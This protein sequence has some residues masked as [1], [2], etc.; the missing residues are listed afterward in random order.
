[1]QKYMLT[2][3]IILNVA[4][5]YG[6]HQKAACPPEP[7]RPPPPFDAPLPFSTA[8]HSG[9]E[10]Q[11]KMLLDA[12][13]NSFNFVLARNA[14]YAAQCKEQEGGGK[15]EKWHGKSKRNVCVRVCSVA[16]DG[17]AMTGGK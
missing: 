3:T 13:Q 7:R 14:H 11:I 10:I 5:N 1:M 8:D 4:S 15:W 12:M 6:C 17:T 9:K 2:T 16:V